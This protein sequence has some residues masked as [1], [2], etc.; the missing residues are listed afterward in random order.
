MKEFLQL[1]DDI[2]SIKIQG[3]INIA[4]EGIKA[5]SDYVLVLEERN[6]KEFRK[7]VEEARNM[8]WHARSTE[9]ALHNGLR[10]L[11][12]QSADQLQE[13]DVEKTKEMMG[14]SSVLYRKMLSESKVSIAKIGAARIQDGSS[15]MTHC[16][17]STA[18]QIFR[19]AF[20]DG[21]Q[22]KVYCTETRP[23]Y[24]GRKTA[25]E[26]LSYGIPVSMVVDSGMR[27]LLKT[28]SIDAVIIGADA[29]T[30]QGTVINKIGSRL[31][32]LA[33]QEMRIPFYSVA[34]LLKFDVGTGLGA[35]TKIEMREEDE[36]WDDCPEGLKI[37]NPAFETIARDLVNALITEMGLFPPSLAYFEVREKFPFMSH[38]FDTEDTK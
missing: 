29:I 1:I 9:P 15:V 11:F 25:K 38:S 36:I 3:A 10:Y 12:Y 16:H 2:K 32:A 37:L 13:Q 21:K 31:L 7:K 4:M 18:T 5:F 28:E 22:F 26:L 30:S 17:S 23:L 24:Q 20:E 35:F 33:S 19:K 34:S 27:W 14:K 6:W 8:L